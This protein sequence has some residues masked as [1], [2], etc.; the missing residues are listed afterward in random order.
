[1][2]IWDEIALVFTEIGWIPAVCIILGLICIIIEIFQ[3]G[4]GVF[5]ITGTI[6]L[7]VGIAVRAYHS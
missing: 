7:V 6:L 3:P 4:F 2:T 1:M 5:G